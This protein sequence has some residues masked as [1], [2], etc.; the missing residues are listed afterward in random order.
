M[1]T[2]AS[3]RDLTVTYRRDGNEV[4]ALKDVGLDIEAG[5]RLA[6]IGESG[7]GK[8]TLALA[9]AGL[10]PASSR[11]D[12]RVD[13]FSSSWDAK[14]PPSVL[15]DISPLKGGDWQFP[16]RPSFCILGDWRKWRQGRNLPP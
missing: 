3:I 11:I 4:A 13:W 1:T 16:R 12:G 14:A 2:L 6:I 5:E 9:I 7:S 15:P 8:S 10:L